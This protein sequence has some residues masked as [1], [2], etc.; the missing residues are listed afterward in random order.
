MESSRPEW[1]QNALDYLLDNVFDILTIAT[2]AYVFIRHEFVRPYGPDDFADLAA[3]ILAVLGLIAVS[4]L[5]Q[6]HRRLTAIENLSQ[7]THDLVAK[8]LGGQVRAEDFFWSSDEKIAAQDFAQA[9]DVYVVGMILNRTVRDHMAAFGDRL[10]AGANLRFLILDWQNETLMSIM[11]YR[12]YGARP[13][14]WWQERIRQTEGHIE[15]IPTSEDVAGTLKVGYLPY[16]PSF[17]MWLI[18]PDKPHGKIHVEIYHHRTP[19]L[20]PKFYLHADG[21]PFWYDL[22]RRQFDLLWQSCQDHGRVRDISYA[23]S[24]WQT[25]GSSGET[26]EL[27]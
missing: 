13:K 26:G 16:F 19:E 25:A 8:H 15:D 23:S 12:S 24:R 21:D 5:W 9:D 27:G 20:N 6:Q 10:A 17:G 22:F 2:T 14:E 18:D 11:P 1:L 3:W 4:G 7:E